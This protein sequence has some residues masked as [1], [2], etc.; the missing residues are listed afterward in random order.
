VESEDGNQHARARATLCASSHTSATMVWRGMPRVRPEQR[1]AVVVAVQRTLLVSC[2]WRQ[3]CVGATARRGKRRL[4]RSPPAYAWR[5]P[6]TSFLAGTAHAK[7]VFPCS[8]ERYWHT[9]L[10]APAWFPAHRPCAKR[11]INCA[12]SAPCRTPMLQRYV[13]LGGG[14]H[15]KQRGGEN[16]RQWR[17]R[18]G[19]WIMAAQ[20]QASSRTRQGEA[21]FFFFFF[22][23]FF[24]SGTD[25][26]RQR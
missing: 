20:A 21:P 24:F 13:L 18:G 7:C 26:A 4:N 8:G 22:F 2:A 19:R 17:W 25:G 10:S 3:R 11:F 9:L 16:A 23:F 14:R 5:S 6:G 15:A 12:V 1:C